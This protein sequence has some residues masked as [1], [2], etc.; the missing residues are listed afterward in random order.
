MSCLY[1][2]G[3]SAQAECARGKMKNREM[4]GELE[5]HGGTRNEG[6]DEVRVRQR[7]IPK[8]F[9]QNYL[10]TYSPALKADINMVRKILRTNN[11]NQGISSTR[12]MYR[13]FS[14]I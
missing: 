6:Q 3:S 7:F 5:M 14:R 2:V 10:S 9:Q 13:S 4:H 11:F 1:L 12:S 8:L